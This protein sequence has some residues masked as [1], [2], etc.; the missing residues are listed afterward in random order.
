VED[1]TPPVI[2]VPANMSVSAT[3]PGGAV[4]TYEVTA[5]DPDNEASTLKLSCAPPS[6][7][8][9]L[10]GETTVECTASDPAGN[11]TH[12]SFRVTV[13]GATE[14]PAVVLRRLLVEVQSA[15]IPHH[16]RFELSDP[17][18]DALR[19]LEMP[20]PRAVAET[21]HHATDQSA[22]RELEWFIDLIA[23]DQSR[24]R[25]KIPAQLASAWSQTARSVE[26]SLGCDSDEESDRHSDGR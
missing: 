4:V 13:T 17:L 9:F 8:T 5:T 12:A 19:S 2:K 18:T 23:R 22:C 3:G 6:G 11:T 26:A 10:I 25:P 21:H 7:S 14:A 24:R 15:P 20:D 16:I 1:K